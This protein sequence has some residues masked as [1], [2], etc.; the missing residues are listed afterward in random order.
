MVK[1]IRV[2]MVNY[3]M[4]CAGIEAFIMNVYRTIDRTKIQFDFLVHYEATMFYDEEILALGGKI[5]R[6]SVREDNNLLKYFGDLKSFFEQHKKYDIVH[7]H[8]ESFGIFYLKAAKNAGV[9]VRIAHSHIAER[10]FG[11]KGFMKYILNH[12]FKTYSTHCLACSNQAGEYIFG[13]NTDFSVWNNAIDLT[14]FKFSNDIRIRTRDQ[15]LITDEQVVI[16]HVGRF[17]EQK[18]HDFLIKVV[19]EITKIKKDIVL[20]LIG[21]GI[22]KDKIRNKVKIFGLEDNVKFLGVRNDVN[23]LYQAMDV[24]VLPSKFEGLPV[25][26]IEAQASGLR[27]VF[28][29]NVTAQVQVTENTKFLSLDNSLN[30]WKTE[31][32]K[33]GNSYTRLDCTPSITNAGYD[34]NTQVSEIEKFYIDVVERR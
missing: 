10:S 7:G 14:K 27:C 1:P 5:Y 13:K 17:N 25:S 32:M 30:E 15:L 22:L 26:G 11:V 19:K 20:L 2:L 34:I 29:D 18:N 4:Q 24:F 21:E 28:S 8:M 23:E 3:K 31:I 16:G 12:G 6:L 33:Y 9:P